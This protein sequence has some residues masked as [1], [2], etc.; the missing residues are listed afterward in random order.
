MLLVITNV[1]TFEHRKNETTSHH[2]NI[3]DHDTSNDPI[4]SDNPGQPIGFKA[5]PQ[6]CVHHGM[7]RGKIDC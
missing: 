6:T 1:I 2:T 7:G 5:W 3:H 4:Q